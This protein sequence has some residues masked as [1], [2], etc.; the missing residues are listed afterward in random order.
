MI[1]GRLTCSKATVF[2]DRAE[3]SSAFKAM[4]YE[5]ISTTRLKDAMYSHGVPVHVPEQ[6]LIRKSSPR[7]IAMFSM[8]WTYPNLC[9]T[10]LSL[11]E[12]RMILLVALFL[13]NR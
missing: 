13:M 3:G 1:P 4:P 11:Q 9:W 8:L 10:I 6:Q 5:T 7:S 12:C 2:A